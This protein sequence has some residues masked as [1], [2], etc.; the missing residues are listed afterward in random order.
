MGVSYCVD[1]GIFVGLLSAEKKGVKKP[2]RDKSYVRQLSSV[3][4][5]GHGF[6]STV[7]TMAIDNF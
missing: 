4:A 3:V 7:P 5:A 2:K 1:V 6:V